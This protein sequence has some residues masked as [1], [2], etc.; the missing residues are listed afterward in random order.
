MLDIYICEDDKKQLQSLKKII[1]NIVLIEDYD[2]NLKLATSDPYELISVVENTTETG[3]YF[4]DIDL[5]SD[6]NG[7]I[8][9][10]KIRKYD[11]RGFIIFITTHAELTYL[12][13]LYK[14]E[15]MDYIIK[16][17]FDNLKKRILDCI[18]N[19]STKHSSQNNTSKKSFTTK[20]DDKII[21]IYYDDILYFE[22]STKIHKI[23]LHSNN[24]IIEFYSKMKDLENILDERFLRCHN[25]FIINKDKIKEIDI[26]NRIAYLINNDECP[27]STRAI[28]KLK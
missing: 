12:T 19:A 15:A 10:E 17:N 26:K 5:H 18:E 20:V 23:I 25:S 22:T 6:I 13:F 7:I 14:V 9:A 21:S 28:K 4:L 3:I 16:D 11:P 1:E 2:I 8:L 24:R 27:I